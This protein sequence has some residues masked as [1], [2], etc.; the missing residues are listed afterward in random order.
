M[1]KLLVLIV[2]SVY[3]FPVSA[4]SLV[5]NNVR[6][7]NPQSSKGLTIVAFDL[8]RSD[9]QKLGMERQWMWNPY[10]PDGA[11]RQL[12]IG[13]KKSSRKAPAKNDTLTV[14]ALL[15]R[16]QVTQ[17]EFY[18]LDGTDKHFSVELNFSGS[19]VAASGLLEEWVKARN[20]YLFRMA[21]RGYDP[22]KLT[23]F[24]ALASQ[25]YL[26]GQEDRRLRSI[27]NRD[28]SRAD[29]LSLLSAD[30]AIEETLQMQLLQASESDTTHLTDIKDVKGVETPAIP[31]EKLLQQQGKAASFSSLDIANLV[32]PARYF[33]LIDKPKQVLPWLETFSNNGNRLLNSARS[34]RLSQKLLDKYLER[35]FLN[36][37]LVS[38][39][40][41]IGSLKQL[42][43]F[44][45][46]LY[47]DHGSDITVLIDI[48][49]KNALGSLLALFGMSGQQ[50]KVHRYGGANDSS[51]AFFARFDR[52]L[53]FSTSEKEVNLALRLAK[54]KGK[55][56][57]GRSAEFRYMLQR[58]PPEKNN[59]G[60][61]VYFSDPFLRSMIS[62]VTKIAQ[63]R[64]SQARLRLNLIS[65]AA[66]LQKIDTG[67]WPDVASLLKSNALKKEWVDSWEG[68]H[69]SLDSQ[70]KSKSTLYGEL[71]AMTPLNRLK[72]SSISAAER[73]A[74]DEYR[75]NY[76]SYWREYF[77]PIGIRISM[78]GALKV[79]T[80]ILPLIDN[81]IYQSLK[82]G[83]TANA[84]DLSFPNISP[85]PIATV[86]L[87]LANDQWFNYATRF[88][89]ESRGLGPLMRNLS[90]QLENRLHVSFYDSDPILSLGSH[91][92]LGAF[93]NSR[94]MN[95]GFGEFLSI[96][97]LISALTQPMSIVVDVKDENPVRQLL[98][99]YSR[100]KSEN[101]E[102][103]DI[104]I[105]KLGVDKERGWLIASNFLPGVTLNFFVQLVGNQLIIC[106]RQYDFIPGN[107]IRV[108]SKANAR[109]VF[110]FA[111]L[112]QMNR[113]L[114]LKLSRAQQLS[115]LNS[116]GSLIPIMLS[117]AKSIDNAMSLHQRLYG[118][119]PEHPVNGVWQWDAKRKL[120]NSSVYGAGYSITLPSYGDK[121]SKQLRGPFDALDNLV[122]SFKFEQDGL[123]VIAKGLNK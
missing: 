123:R 27:M 64:R 28:R 51:S 9:L 44:G 14:Y 20:N 95:G 84:V 103:P 21:R 36:K 94:L 30:A 45:P 71:G 117:G 96:P 122:L 39:L 8:R 16:K 11:L 83:L 87:G 34:V 1:A 66:M 121:V 110:D 98:N 77:D 88:L 73:N 119:T 75:D 17:V 99:R 68:D 111:Q 113:P 19:S 29:L 54:N 93:S 2:L 106:N 26:D 101:T 61:F 115:T 92:F 65:N 69:I 74:Y 52:W 72:I 89:S 38:K 35:L 33:V 13:A 41:E 67:H 4:N 24:I 80:F 63:L 104:T 3:C 57:L 60:L 91:D 32:P 78:E 109:L 100:V 58:L 47:L 46:D 108:A 53:I 105:L 55:G 102:Q 81:S 56:S 48:A 76:N 86:S 5:A 6:S 97:L 7:S 120:L 22:Q 85:A 42:A 40:S 49:D 25:A 62:P 70:G 15:Q 107:Q 114:Y 10:S 12:Y 118:V 37:T 59:A 90:P 18:S 50:G 112:N 43:F 79:E 116:S 82:A 23:Q 31:F